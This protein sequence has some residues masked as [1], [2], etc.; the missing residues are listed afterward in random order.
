MN[1]L[2]YSQHAIEPYLEK[3]YQ[4]PGYFLEIGCWRGNLISQT[5]YLESQKGWKG[6]CV[7]PFPMD[8]ENRTCQLCRKALSG[9]GQVREF[10]QVSI[11][12]RYGGDVSYFSGFRDT[13]QTHWPLI[14][15][16]CDYKIIGLATITFPQLMKEFSTPRFVEFLSV[17]TEGSELEI[18][19]TIPFDEIE[20]GLIVFEH[21]RNEI[22]QKGVGEILVKNGYKLLESLFVDDIYVRSK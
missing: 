16:H 21:N 22:V 8:F 4:S 17:D 12:R 15:E 11:D 5:L 7:D 13:L 20:F 3:M 9:D 2:R 1:D 14:E 18:F 10:V 6:L 19:Q